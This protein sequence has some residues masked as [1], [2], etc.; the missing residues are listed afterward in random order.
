MSC[1]YNVTIKPS[2]VI[3]SLYRKEAHHLMTKIPTHSTELYFSC[4]LV[5][6]LPPLSK[7][8]ISST[9]IDVQVQKT[10]FKVLLNVCPITMGLGELSAEKP[11]LVMGEQ[12]EST[13]ALLAPL[14]RNSLNLSY[15]LSDPAHRFILKLP[16]E[17]QK[18]LPNSSSPDCQP[19]APRATQVTPLLPPEHTKV[20]PNLACSCI[21]ETKCY[22]IP[23]RCICPRKV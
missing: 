7:T 6:S 9:E 1:F 12:E 18:E 22:K 19:P 4:M 14:Q 15:P 10:D 20:P 17:P 8:H 13:L 11:A 3:P 16:Q 21:R 2:L 23:A 5:L